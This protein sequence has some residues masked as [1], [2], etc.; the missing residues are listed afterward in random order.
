MR[1]SSL[2]GVSQ[3]PISKVKVTSRGLMSFFACEPCP[4]SLSLVNLWIS[5]SGVEENL[6]KD[7]H[8][9]VQH[10]TGGIMYPTRLKFLLFF[11]WLGKPVCPN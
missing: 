1:A 8:T 7:K 6:M 2:D 9:G 11:T 4:I 3:V 10:V 5:L